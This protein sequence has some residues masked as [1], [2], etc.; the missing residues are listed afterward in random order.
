MDNCAKNRKLKIRRKLLFRFF[1]NSDHLFF[2]E[3]DVSTIFFHQIDE[4]TIAKKLFLNHFP[5]FHLFSRSIEKSQKMF[6]D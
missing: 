6:E 2:N 1:K 5:N 4:L 3:K